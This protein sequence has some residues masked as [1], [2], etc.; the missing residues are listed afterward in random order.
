MKIKTME[1]LFLAEIKDLYDAEKQLVKALPKMAE[2]ATSE[3]LRGLFSEHLTQTR[4]HVERLETVFSRIGEKAS[5]ESC[6]AMEGLL[7]EGEEIIDDIDESPVRDAGLIA[8]GNRVEHYEIAGYGSARTFAQI[9]GYKEAADLLEKT[10]EE[11]KLADQKLTR[12]AE[13]MINQ[14]AVRYGT[15]RT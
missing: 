5:G 3:Q 12:I 7:E 14:E 10:L 11:E 13:S 15:G 1:D 8:A 6:E 9:L 4:G 2:A